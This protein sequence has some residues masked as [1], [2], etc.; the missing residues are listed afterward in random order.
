MHLCLVGELTPLFSTTCLSPQKCLDM[1]STL[2]QYSPASLVL[3]G[4]RGCIF[5]SHPLSAR[6]CLSVDAA[7]PAAA[8]PGGSPLRPISRSVSALRLRQFTLM[9]VYG[10]V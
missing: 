1:K 9:Y 8:P 7:R 2:A 5:S 10:R 4:V 3:D 6:V